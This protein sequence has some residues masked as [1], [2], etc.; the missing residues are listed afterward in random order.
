MGDRLIGLAFQSHDS[1]DFERSGYVVPIRVIRHF[2]DDI[3]DG[4][5]GGVP[6]LGVFWQRTENEA[7]RAYARLSPDQPGVLISRV[8]HGA[9]AHGVLREGDVLCAVDG[10]SIARD[11]SILL[12]EH[13]RVDFSYLVSGCQVGAEVEVDVLREGEP[14]RLRV[15]L[16]RPVTLVSPPRHEGRPTYFL[17]AGLVF[18]PLTYDYMA[19]WDWKDVSPRFRHYYSNLLPSEHRKQIILVSQVLAH[20]V[21]VGYH[22]LRGAVIERINGVDIVDMGD[23]P[24]ALQ[25]PHGRHHV[26]EMDCYGQLG[27]SSDYHAVFGTRIVL[28]AALAAKATPEILATYGI[29]SDRSSDFA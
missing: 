15:K 13:D 10:V 6:D 7:L 8:V 4:H 23:V 27:D 22:Q 5:V 19:C 26:I 17:F 21:N 11:G 25:K 18:T 1:K 2:L 28:D 29:P 12:R 14:L 16:A 20:D 3:R 9:S 24:R